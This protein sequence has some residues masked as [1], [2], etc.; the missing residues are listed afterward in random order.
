M[1]VSAEVNKGSREEVSVVLGKGIW[2]ASM[3]GSMILRLYG[4]FYAPLP[5]CAMNAEVKRC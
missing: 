2:R 4:S 3:F 5:S 1:V